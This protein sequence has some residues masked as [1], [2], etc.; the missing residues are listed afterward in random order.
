MRILAA[1]IA[2]FVLASTGAAQETLEV[3]DL[4][5]HP[6]NVSFPSGERLVMHL[7]SGDFRIVGGDDNRIVVHF[8]GANAEKARKLTVRFALKGYEGNLRVSGGPKNELQVTIEIPRETDL[9]VRMPGGDLDVEGVHGNEDV[10]LVG[11]DLTVGVGNPR[12]Y[13]RVDAS[14]RFGDVYGNIFGEPHGWMGES[15]K[16]EGSGK[17]RLHAH[18]FAGDLTLATAGSKEED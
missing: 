18:V 13:A 1:G 2:A 3:K 16:A 6:F 4:Q 9:K 8:E 17:Y 12:D 5:N 11:G 14:V 7:Q 15:V 10:S